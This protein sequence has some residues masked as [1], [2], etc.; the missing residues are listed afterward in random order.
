MRISVRKLPKII[1]HNI[2]VTFIAR[3]INDENSSSNLKTTDKFHN[4]KLV[5]NR[6]DRL[7]PAHVLC[8]A[9]GSKVDAS[10]KT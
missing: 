2:C 8:S 1:L 6:V 9:F 3:Y 4:Y 10:S 5:D 7:L